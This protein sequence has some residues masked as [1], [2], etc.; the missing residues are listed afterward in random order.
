MVKWNG[1]LVASLILCA[2]AIGLVLVNELGNSYFADGWQS[3]R[4]E[5]DFL[6]LGGC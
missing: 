6:E 2:V 5:S 3:I 1:R 4:D